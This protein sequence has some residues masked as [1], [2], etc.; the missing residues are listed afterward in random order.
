M[1]WEANLELTTLF[2]AI[3]INFPATITSGIKSLSASSHHAEKLG[4]VRRYLT[5]QFDDHHR[6]RTFAV[7]DKLDY[8]A[9]HCQQQILLPIMVVVFFQF[10]LLKIKVRGKSISVARY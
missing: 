7:I 9:L 6:K 5:S 4:L 2:M 10:S 3:H 8:L 1:L